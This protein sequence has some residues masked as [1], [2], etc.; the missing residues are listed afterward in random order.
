MVSSGTFREDL[1]YRI[2]LITVSLPALRERPDDIP[3]LV[4]HFVENLKTIYGRN[5]LSV[6]PGALKW[7]TNQSWPG[8]VRELKNVV[9]RTVLISRENVLDIDSFQ[10]QLQPARTT[11]PSSIPAVG[12]LTIEEMEQ[13]MIRKAMEYHSNN[14]SRVARSL[15]LSRAALYRRLEKYGIDVLTLRSRFIFFAVLIHAILLGLSLFLLTINKYYFVAAEILIII[16]VLVTIRL[17]RSFLRPLNLLSAGV[18][19]IKARDFTAT[20]NST[21]RL[22]LTT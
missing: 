3:L 10:S 9:E 4:Q 20:F 8:N 21:G 16:S 11:Q 15:G 7:L 1:Y 5:D 22:I 18:E 17:Y 13:S 6:T 19:A 2:N 14:I 12:T